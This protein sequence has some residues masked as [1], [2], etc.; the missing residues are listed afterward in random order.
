MDTTFAGFCPEKNAVPMPLIEL[1][2]TTDW[3]GIISESKDEPP[4]ENLLVK[5]TCHNIDSV[6]PL[7]HNGMLTL[8]ADNSST[9]YFL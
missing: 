5:S 3:I 4:P 6:G 2:L 9:V 8:A 1:G 7:D